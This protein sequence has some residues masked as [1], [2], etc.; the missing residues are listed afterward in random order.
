MTPPQEHVGQAD[1]NSISGQID[2]AHATERAVNIDRTGTGNRV[3][4]RR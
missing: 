3:M 2:E 4:T 1:L